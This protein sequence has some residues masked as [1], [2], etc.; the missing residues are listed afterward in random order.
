MVNGSC[1]K[2]LLVNMIFPACPYTHDLNVNLMYFFPGNKYTSGWAEGCHSV[3]YRV[4]FTMGPSLYNL[5][6][7]AARRVTWCRLWDMETLLKS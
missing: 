5:Q 7:V 4:A 3:T 6:V 2:P 1:V